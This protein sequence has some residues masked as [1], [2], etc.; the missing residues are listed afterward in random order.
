MLV[1]FLGAAAVAQA[2]DPGAS[3]A[4]I[5]VSGN[6]DAQAMQQDLKGITTS[7]LPCLIQASG[8]GKSDAEAENFCFCKNRSLVET[9]LLELK[10]LRGKHPEWKGKTL[11]IVSGSPDNRETHR[12]GDQQIVEIESSLAQASKTCK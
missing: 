6:A 9:R 5:D 3:A 12:F 10:K 1:I 8:E 2:A 7:V 4:E 11:K